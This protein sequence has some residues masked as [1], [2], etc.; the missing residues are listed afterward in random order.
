[1]IFVWY[2]VDNKEPDNYEIGLLNELDEDN[3]KSITQVNL[4]DFKMHIFEP[5]QNSADYYHFKTVHKYLANPIYSKLIKVYHKIS[6]NYPIYIENNLDSSNNIPNNIKY[7]Q[8]VINESINK[9]KLLGKINLPNFFAQLLSTTIVIETPSLV[10]FKINNKY[11]GNFR[12]ILTFTPKDKFLQKSQISTWCNG[13]WP[14]ILAKI[15]THMIISTVNQDRE[16]WEHKLH[17]SPRNWVKGDGP[18]AQYN[19]WLN[20]F[21]TENSKLQYNQDW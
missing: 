6:S 18:F 19:N 9:L 11:L 21:Y 2:H 17:I 1:M 4:N 16:V 13:R 15:L 7:K 3:Y 5:S 12:A 8:I 14:K 20:Q 10:M